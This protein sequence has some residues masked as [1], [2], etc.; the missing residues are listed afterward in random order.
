MAYLF[1]LFFLLPLLLFVKSSTA[2][3]SLG[4][5]SVDYIKS[6]WIE[7]QYNKLTLEE[8]IG[9]L[10]MVAAYSGGPNYNETAITKLV[11]NGQVGGLIFMQGDAVKQATQTNKY[12]EIANV[13]LLIAM[14]A[15]WG[16]GMR[17]T[18]VKDMPHQMLLGAT[19]DST[20]VYKMGTAIAEQCKR[21][22]VHV[23]FAPVVDVNNNPNNPVINESNGK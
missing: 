14:D 6:K 3:T 4:T 10:F 21:L 16:L 13:P 2:Q 15:E 20:I 19:H 23:D 9:Q 5:S 12:Q 8:R 11:Q 1:R 7:D 18:G 17:L 22:G